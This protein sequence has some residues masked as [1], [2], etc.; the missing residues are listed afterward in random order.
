MDKWEGGQQRGK[1]R[2]GCKEKD[3]SI[4]LVVTEHS[5]L[6]GIIVAQAGALFLLSRLLSGKVR[7]TGLRT[8]GSDGEREG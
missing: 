3:P 5:L 7:L 2:G 6:F 1:K 8:T 4:S